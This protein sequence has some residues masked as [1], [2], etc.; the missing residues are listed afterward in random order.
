MIL[1][2]DLQGA[3][4][5]LHSKDTSVHVSTCT[6]YDLNAFVNASCV[7]VVALVTRVCFYVSSQ[8]TSGRFLEQRIDIK[9]CV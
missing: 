6:S 2:R 9:F 8:N 3:V 1:S 5:L 4:L 7:E